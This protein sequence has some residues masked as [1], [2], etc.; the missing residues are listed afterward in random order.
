MKEDTT[1]VAPLM[2]ENL[3]APRLLL[4]RTNMNKY[5]CDKAYRFTV[6]VRLDKWR[7]SKSM[8]ENKP[9]NEY[10]NQ[11]SQMIYHDLRSPQELATNPLDFGRLL[12]LGHKFCIQESQP[13]SK[14]LVST[15]DRFNR[16]VRL[17]YT[18]A[19]QELNRKCE[20]KIYVKSTWGPGLASEE[21]ENI[22]AEFQ[23][24]IR[25]ER[26]ISLSQPQATNLSKHQ[27]GILN[28]LRSN[29]EII[30]LI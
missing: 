29:K 18:F 1:L 3:R 21:T 24:N 7:N 28:Y 20:K 4:G 23:Q 13:K 8:I 14:T 16:D 27:F 25:S 26:E 22:L 2:Y 17:K 9:V 30:V 6:D 11:V 19:G 5:I 15:F 12:G 10:N